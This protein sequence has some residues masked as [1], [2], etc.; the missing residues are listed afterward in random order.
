MF[1]FFCTE[2]L[3]QSIIVVFDSIG[4]LLSGLNTFAALS[5]QM[6]IKYLL[7]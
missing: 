7:Y 1:V 6:H 2:Y 5:R 3:D 4:Q